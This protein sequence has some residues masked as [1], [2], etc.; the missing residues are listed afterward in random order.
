MNHHNDVIGP[1]WAVFSFTKKCT[2]SDT[3]TVNSPLALVDLED[4]QVS[5]DSAQGSS[6]SLFVSLRKTAL[7]RCLKLACERP[8]EEAVISTVKW[9]SAFLTGSLRQRVKWSTIN[10]F[11]LKH[12]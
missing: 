1:I 7:K 8:M 5:D 10:T 4:L 3:V 9:L 6:C 2:K 11:D 12:E